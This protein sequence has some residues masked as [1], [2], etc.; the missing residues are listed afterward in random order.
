MLTLVT[1]ISRAAAA[2]AAV[3]FVLSGAM[4]TYEVAARY[5]FVKP[6]IW[7][8]ELS[9]LCLIWGGLLAMAWLLAARRHITVNAVTDLLPLPAQRVCAGLALLLVVVFSVIV[10]YWG[11]EIFYDSFRRGRTTGSLLN[12]PVWISELPVPLGFV[13]LALQG[14]V[15]ILRL[16]RTAAPGLG[17]SES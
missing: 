9:Q 4:L 14:V 2:V 1:R 17:A 6:T 8:A 15:E 12:L 11:W 13:L 3:L 10:A 16:P 7:A 5:F